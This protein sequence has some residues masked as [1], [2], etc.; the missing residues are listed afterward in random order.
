M[1]VK[2]RKKPAFK[3][4]LAIGASLLAIAFW[5]LH[6]QDIAVLNSQGVIADKEKSL[7]ITATLL[8]MLV[9]IPVYILTIAIALKYREKNHRSKKYEP[10]WDHSRWLEGV[11][12]A[13]PLIIIGILSVITWRSSYALDPFKPLQSTAAPVDVQVVALD[14]KWLFIYPEKGVASINEAH[15]PVNTP[16]RFSIT[17]DSVMNSFWIPQLS[18]Q[19]YAMP[20]M[21]T[22]L[23]VMARNTGR[24][25]GSS[26]NISGSG[27]AG[28][29]FNAKAE[30]QTA[31]NEWIK[32][33]AGSKQNLTLGN[34]HELAKPSKNNTVALYSKVDKG[35]FD[36][37][38][39]KY[40]APEV[41]NE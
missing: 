38:V 35:L 4:I 31:F 9:I 22:E 14:W 41:S 27:F 25:Q 19:I 32:E 11:W 33:A 16:V 7:I 8:G 10:T 17:S 34:Y 40:M 24:Y 5:W 20:G 21:A 13:I 26:A 30:S 15:F 37:I 36:Y 2:I 29:T 28:M 1:A 18:G 6:N 39:M 12:W 3:V 23:N